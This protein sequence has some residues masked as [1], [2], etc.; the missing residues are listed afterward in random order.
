MSEEKQNISTFENLQELPVIQVASTGANKGTLGISGYAQ[1][2]RIEKDWGYEL[3]Y[4]NNELYCCKLLFIKSK[5]SCSYH[6]HLTKHETLLV[7]SGVLEIDTTQNKIKRTYQVKQGEAFIVAP[8]FIHSL[9]ATTESV[10]LI[11]SSTPSY[12]TDSIRIASGS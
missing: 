9:R 10:T 11:E 3:I 12:D 7:M 5:Q 8:G 6:L 2:L 1:P 4:Q